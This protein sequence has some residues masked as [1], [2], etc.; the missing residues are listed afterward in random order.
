MF[1]EINF[2]DWIQAIC[3]FATFILA[4]AVV[5]QQNRIKTL[6]DVVNSLDEQAR[7][8][9]QL[10]SFEMRSRINDVQPNFITLTNK[11]NINHYVCNFKNVGQRARNVSFEKISNLDTL[12]LDN[13]GNK[14]IPKEDTV[15]GTY[16]ISVADS[17]FSFR[18]RYDDNNG[19]QFFQVVIGNKSRL[20]INL[21]E[22]AS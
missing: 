18:I 12:N 21:P 1:C 10:L 22:K 14:V 11:W 16:T 4:I 15:N 20:V 19:N 9:Q 6:T 2:P 5:I 13:P 3:A 17:S 7:I 8:S